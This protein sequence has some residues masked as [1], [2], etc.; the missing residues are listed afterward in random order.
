[1]DKWESIVLCVLF[2]TIAGVNIFTDWQNGEAEKACY[3]A[4]A[5]GKGDIKDC[6]K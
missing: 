4:V 5:A 2:L 1:M 6:K 3:Q